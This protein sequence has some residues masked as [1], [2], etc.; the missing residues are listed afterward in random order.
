MKRIISLTLCIVLFVLLIIPVNAE[1]E[2]L[3]VALFDNDEVIV[4]ENAEEVLPIGSISKTFAAAIILKLCEDGVVALDEPVIKYLPEFKMED[5][6]YKNITIRMLLD[7]TSGLYGSTLKNTLLYGEADTWAH[8]NLLSLLSLQRLKSDPGRTASYSNDGYVL[9]ELIAEWVTGKNFAQ[10]LNEYVNEP[11]KLKS[12]VTP[13]EYRGLIK[14]KVTTA[15]SGGIFS[16]AAE[17]CKF[18]NALFGGTVINDKM[19]SEMTK[20]Y[21]EDEGIEHFGLGLDDVSVYPFDKYGIRAF[22]KGGDTLEYSS[23]ILILPDYG[24]SAAVCMKNGSSLLC[25]AKA[26]SEAIDYL[27]ERNGVQIEYYNAVDAKKID[28]SDIA[29]M[30]KSEGFYISNIGEYRFKISGE[31]GILEDLYRDTRVKYEYIGGG[32][33]AYRGEILSFDGEYMKKSG[34]I[35]LSDGAMSPYNYKFAQ[36]KADGEEMSETWKKRDRKFYLICDEAYN[37]ALMLSSM[38]ITNVYFAENVN[39]YVG[40][41]RILSDDEAIADLDMPG[42]LGRDLTDLKFFERDGKEYVNAQGW[43]FVDAGTV[44]DIY[45]G[46][47][48]FATVGEDGFIKW[49]RVGKAVGKTLLAEAD[50]KSSVTVYNSD[51]SLCWS[52]LLSNDGCVLPENGYIAFNA[53]VGT[54]FK[55]SLN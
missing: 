44:I 12:T 22:V 3:S 46:D 51:G 48:S 52:S 25:R 15:A 20:S 43:T 40:C 10:L 7:H 26:I 6:R 27:S 9:L 39:S 41:M 30:K 38:P 2:F 1:N 17:L 54:R 5:A 29:I 45:P 49:Y 18:G 28:K 23:G 53:S 11:L 47:S 36:K 35:T 33:F 14:E 55:I 19:L 32:N 21:S 50:E 4:S 37:S 13:N 16:T 24:I 31:Y 34:M 42:S 8:D